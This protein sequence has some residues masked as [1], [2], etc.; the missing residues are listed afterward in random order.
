ME[1]T[2]TV[3]G[4]AISLGVTLTHVYNLVR[5]ERLPGAVKVDGEWKVP[6]AALNTYLERRRRR[7]KMPKRAHSAV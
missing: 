3:R 4:T 2:L 1:G 7:E 6:Q 5:A